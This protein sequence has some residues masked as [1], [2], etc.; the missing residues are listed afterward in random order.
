MYKAQKSPAAQHVGVTAFYLIVAYVCED[1]LRHPPTR[2]YLSSCVEILGQVH[3]CKCIFHCVVNCVL[4]SKM[5]IA[6][7]LHL[8]FIFCA[9]VF[10]QGNADECSRVLRTI[11]D[12][13]RLCPLVAPF[14]TPNAAP[15][16]LVFLYQ[17]IVMSLDLSSADVIFLLLTKVREDS[18]SQV[19]IMN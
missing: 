15:S 18:C 10:I 11:L 8:T 16:Q 9:K 5:H 7:F 17:D 14:F 2:Q 4:G 6:V 12:Q 1:T 13:R 3:T 19:Y